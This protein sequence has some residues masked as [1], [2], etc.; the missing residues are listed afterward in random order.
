MKLEVGKRYVNRD[1]E[2]S[3]VLTR[4]HDRYYP[5]DC[6]V[7]NDCFTDCGYVWENKESSGDLIFEY[8]E[9]TAP[10][11]ITNLTAIYD[12][13]MELVITNPYHPDIKARLETAAALRAGIDAL[14]GG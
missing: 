10:N 14:R 1:G 12:T 4:D 13:Q 7:S 2:I 9:H 5:F 11:H 3:G 8:I 6:P